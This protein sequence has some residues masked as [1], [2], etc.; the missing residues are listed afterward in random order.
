MADRAENEAKIAG[1]VPYKNIVPLP[2]IIADYLGVNKQSKKVEVLYQSIIKQAGSEF[3]VALDLDEI[4]LK[5]IMPRNLAAGIIR[6]RD[7][8]V[9]LTPGFDGQYGGVEIFSDS[10]R[11]QTATRVKQVSLF[12]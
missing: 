11:D 7:D 9:K 6:M 2:E 3:H 1:R 5:K 4:E 12:D 10:Q 8:Q